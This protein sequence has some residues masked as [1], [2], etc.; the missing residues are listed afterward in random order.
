MYIYGC[1]M[2]GVATHKNSDPDCPQDAPELKGRGRREEK[3]HGAGQRK[4]RDGSKCGTGNVTQ[5][6]EG[7]GAGKG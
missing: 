3:G 6:R 7:K 4:S 5:G 2:T 1:E